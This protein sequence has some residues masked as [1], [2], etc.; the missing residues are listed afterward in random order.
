MKINILH[1]LPYKNKQAKTKPYML[2]NTI[3]TNMHTDAI[4]H[5]HACLTCTQK[6]L[7]LQKNTYTKIHVFLISL[8]EAEGQTSQCLRTEIF[9]GSGGGWSLCPAVSSQPLTSLNVI[10]NKCCCLIAYNHPSPVMNLISFQ[11]IISSDS[12][13]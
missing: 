3:H 1:L 8:D 7:H 13:D 5:N 12:T 9:L 2:L 4:T 6:H 10:W 11:H